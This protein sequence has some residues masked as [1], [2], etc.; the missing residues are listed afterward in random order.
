MAPQAGAK[1]EDGK[2]V[3]RCDN[4]KELLEAF[5]TKKKLLNAVFMLSKRE[6]I[7]IVMRYGLDYSLE[8]VGKYFSVTRDRVR[9][10]EVKALFEI[11]RRAGRSG[12]HVTTEYLSKNLKENLYN[13][14]GVK[15]K[16]SIEWSIGTS[17]ELPMLTT[18]DRILTEEIKLSSIDDL[19]LSIRAHNCLLAAG[20]KT[21]G[22]LVELSIDQLRA[23]KNF[24]E[25]SINEIKD[26]LRVFGA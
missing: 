6:Y 3:C 5:E 9:Q 18:D 25:K 24:G 12:L 11:G 1:M 13:L 15:K 17:F 2:P 23:I 19:Q 20:V 8:E 21:I 16:V 14:P 22:E 10:I 4:C 7:V 26:T